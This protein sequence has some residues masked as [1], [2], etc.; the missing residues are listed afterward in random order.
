MAR[1]SKITIDMF[2]ELQSLIPTKL[3]YRDACNATVIE[4]EA[5]DN[6]E[7]IEI[8]NNFFKEKEIEIYY[9]DDKKYIYEK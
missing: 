6:K 2:L 5:R 8:I 3:H 4:N 9:S 7:V 1:R